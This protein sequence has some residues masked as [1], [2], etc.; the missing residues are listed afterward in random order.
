M[1]D[2]KLIELLSCFT[3]KELKQ[4]KLMV[5]SPYFNNQASIRKLMEFIMEFAPDFNHPKLTYDHAFVH[6]YGKKDIQS[7]QQT[8][9]LK[10]ISKLIFYIIKDSLIVSLRTN[11]LIFKILVIASQSNFAIK[12]FR[13]SIE[14]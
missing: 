4:L 8:A 14:D 5:D 10:V 3:P 2:S 9:V 1:I 12:E 7:D 6:I 13:Y 11:I